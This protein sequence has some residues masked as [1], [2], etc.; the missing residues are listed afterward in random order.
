RCGNDFAKET[1]LTDLQAIAAD[2][3]SKHHAVFSPGIRVR[4]A[5]EFLNLTVRPGCCWHDARDLNV[6]GSIRGAEERHGLWTTLGINEIVRGTD[7]LETF[8]HG[9]AGSR[10]RVH[11]NGKTGNEMLH[12]QLTDIIE[13]S[14]EQRTHAAHIDPWAE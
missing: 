3:W 9:C 13:L 14:V 12:L 11:K 6:V 2:G 5:G 8:D 4:D 7:H 10:N 1:H